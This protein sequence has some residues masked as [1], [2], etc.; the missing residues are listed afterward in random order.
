MSVSSCCCKADMDDYGVRV[1]AKKTIYK[2]IMHNL[3]VVHYF[4]GEEETQQ[5]MLLH[6]PIICPSALAVARLTWTITEFESP[7]KKL[8]TKK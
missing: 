2:K 4:G 3:Y 7:P 8:Y 6:S 1:S 5:Q